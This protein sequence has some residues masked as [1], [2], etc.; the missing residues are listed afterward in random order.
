SRGNLSQRLDRAI[1]NSE[2]DFFATNYVVP[3][4]ILHAEFKELV[5]KTW[6]SNDGIVKNLE[7][8]KNV[9]QDWNKR[10]YENIFIRKRTIF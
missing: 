10:V 9:V 8:F 6:R 1:C 5:R 4:W 7:C 2:W 3:S